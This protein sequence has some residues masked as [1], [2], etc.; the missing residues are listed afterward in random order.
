[1]DKRK[2]IL[3]W[4]SQHIS[5]RLFPSLALILFAATSVAA[6]TPSP[7]APL[8]NGE[9]V[10]VFITFKFLKVYAIDELNETYSID[11][12]FT[13]HWQGHNRINTKPD[14]EPVFYIGDSATSAL[15][16]SVWWSAFEFMNI[17]GERSIQAVS[18]EVDPAG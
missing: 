12:Y 4:V 8:V 18:L 16:T 7:V 3:W 17:I 2:M 9:P 14:Q 10:S 5:V 15:G 11:G 1:M 6:Q 13:A